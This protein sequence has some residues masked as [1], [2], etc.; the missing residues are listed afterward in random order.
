[1]GSEG[2]CPAWSQCRVRSQ[3]SPGGCCLSCRYRRAWTPPQGC[4]GV[5]RLSWLTG[6]AGLWLLCQAQ[7]DPGSAWT[8]GI[9]R[10][11]QAP[12]AHLPGLPPAP[13]QHPECSSGPSASDLVLHPHGCPWPSLCSFKFVCWLFAFVQS[14][15][16]FETKATSEPWRD[17]QV[18][19][20]QVWVKTTSYG[21]TVG[22]G[23][24][25]VIP[26]LP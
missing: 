15:N 20:V 2:R 22:S 19:G 5:G 26:S 13:T 10:P 25:G 16:V 9:H 18:C 12:H 8:E 7:E 4:W 23:L 1:M 14:G 6:R 3:P 11:R 24:R 21:F 17:V